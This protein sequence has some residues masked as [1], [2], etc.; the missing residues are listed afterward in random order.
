MVQEEEHRRLEE[1]RERAHQA[2]LEEEKRLAEEEEARVK[3]N[4]AKEQVLKEQSRTMS[5]IN[6]LDNALKVFQGSLGLSEV[7]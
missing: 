4:T 7:S 2:A 6:D 5:A 3:A 1:E